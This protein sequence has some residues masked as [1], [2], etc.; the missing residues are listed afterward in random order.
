MAWKTQV[1]TTPRRR[2]ATPTH[3][4][5]GPTGR[6]RAAPAT[7]GGTSR[8][9]VYHQDATATGFSHLTRPRPSRPRR[10]RPATP[11]TRVT[12][13]VS[14]R[15]GGGPSAFLAAS[16]SFVIRHPNPRAPV[17]LAVT[18]LVWED[19]TA[20]E[21][22]S[23]RQGPSTALADTAHLSRPYE[24]PASYVRQSPR[25]T[26]WGTVD[27]TGPAARGPPD[28]SSASRHPA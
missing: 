9:A 2:P 4:G 5:R 1:G 24:S 18:S 25:R 26:T 7:P 3:L 14:A 6:S 17:T 15:T 12:C 27:S 23:R 8:P 10:A 11:P 16:I 28:L 13:R 19:P 21:Q 20:R 22:T